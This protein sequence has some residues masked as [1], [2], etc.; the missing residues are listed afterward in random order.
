MKSIVFILPVKGG[1]GGAHSVVQEVSEMIKMGVDAKIAVDAKNCMSMKST[2]F[3][4]PEVVANLIS[5]TDESNLLAQIKNDSTVIATIF[6]T[7]SMVKN[8]CAKN[9]TLVPAY[10]VQDY[11]PLFSAK[12]TDLWQ[13]AYDSYTLIK[14]CILFAKTAWLQN[15]VL[16]NHGVSV[17]K[18]EPSID[19][20]VYFPNFNKSSKM[21]TAMVR[22]KS[23][24]R[25]PHRTMRILRAIQKNYPEYKICIFGCTEEEIIEND[26]VRDFEYENLGVLKRLQVSQVL[27]EAELF[28]DLSDF[29]AFGRTG[30]EAMACGCIPV[31]T[32]YGGVYEYAVDQENSFIVDTKSDEAMLLGVSSYLEMSDEEKNTIR[33]QAIATAQRFSIRKAALSELAIF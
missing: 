22:P 7:V 8:L 11:E 25:A 19:Q 15:V 2:Y 21:I 3:D 28:L 1:G 20:S 26:L 24:R 31:I 27:R 5:Y 17:H 33:H 12:G 18:V 14:D 4:M 30:L 23:P 13:Q 6:T 29:Q 10:Y 9:D 32:K 16:E